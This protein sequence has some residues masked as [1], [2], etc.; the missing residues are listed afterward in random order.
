MT[1]TDTTAD[2]NSTVNT[3][4]DRIPALIADAEASDAT[5]AHLLEAEATLLDKLADIIRPAIRALGTRPLVE[6]KW[7]GGQ[8]GC[9]PWETEQRAKWRGIKVAGALEE[10]SRG[11]DTDGYYEGSTIWLTATGWRRLTYSGTWSRWQGAT[12]EWETTD[13]SLTSREVAKYADGGVEQVVT[14]LAAVVAAAGSRANA[15]AA[16]KARAAKLAALVALL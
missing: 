14:A 2:I 7:S 1:D 8:N 12:S 16:A 5:R 4:V 9:N 15:I 3:I 6:R 13:E 10:S 11:R